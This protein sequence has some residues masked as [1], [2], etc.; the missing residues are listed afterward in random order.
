MTFILHSDDLIDPG[1]LNYTSDLRYHI[2]ILRREYHLKILLFKFDRY[3]QKFSIHMNQRCN[4]LVHD[5]KRIRN[6]FKY[7]EKIA[8]NLIFLARKSEKFLLCSRMLKRNS[9]F[10][11]EK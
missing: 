10:K 3:Q 9:K 11:K 1:N 2:E 4:S 8:Q 7:H 6:S 5:R